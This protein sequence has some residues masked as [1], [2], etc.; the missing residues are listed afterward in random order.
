MARVIRYDDYAGNRQFDTARRRSG[1]I[2]D[3]DFYAAG[4]LKALDDFARLSLW[5]A[6][7][8]YRYEGEVESRDYEQERGE[9]NALYR[10]DR[11]T[12]LLAGVEKEQGESAQGR[13]GLRYVLPLMIETELFVTTDGEVEAEFETEFQLAKRLQLHAEYETTDRYHV[14]L[15]YRLDEHLSLEGAYTS[16]VDYSLGVKLRF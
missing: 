10:L 9:V 4:E 7:N 8:R 1:D 3:D 13:V 6:N 15:E 16:D 12:Q 11:W 5:A 2:M 14:G